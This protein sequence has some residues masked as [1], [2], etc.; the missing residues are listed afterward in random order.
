[1]GYYSIYLTDVANKV[2][3]I[4][5]PFVNYEYNFLW[6]GV[7]IALHV[8]Q[9]RMSAQIDDLYFVRFYLNNLFVITSCS[10]EEHLAK[11]KEV[12]KRLQLSWAQMQ[13]W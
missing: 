3:T 6:M 2:C 5:T 10:S 11:A 8:F 7:C 12:M 13:Y 1:M 4:S 9:E